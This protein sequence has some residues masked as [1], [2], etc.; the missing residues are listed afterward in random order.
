MPGVV[1]CHVHMLLSHLD[2]W[3]LATAPISLRICEAVDNLA[4]TLDAG[5]TYA[6]DAG[7]ID[8]GVAQAVRTGLIRG[9]RL[10]VS[11][12][13]ICQTGGHADGWVLSGRDMPTILP[14]LPGM[15]VTVVDGP[16]D[17]RRA[18]R[19]LVRAGADVLK[20]ATSGGVLS[21]RDDPRRRHLADDELAMLRSE[22]AAAG[23]RIMAHAHAN[24]GVKAAVRGGAASVEHGVWLDDEAIQMMLDAGTWLVPTLAAPREVLRYDNGAGAMPPELIA[25]ARELVAAHSDSFA[26]ALD[27]GVKVAL[28]SDSG[29]IAHGDN[30]RELELMVEAGMSGADGWR[31]ATA[32]GAALLGV[33]DRFGALEV[34]KRAD[35]IGVQGD[36]FNVTALRERID[37]VVQDGAIVRARTDA[38]RAEQPAS[39]AAA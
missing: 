30:L 1:D 39:G 16:E 32:G 28:G 11:I 38:V 4:T 31:A 2:L 34:G 5:V 7:G 21:P 3:R 15:P 27:A 10:Q 9:P 29:V 19:S 18:V 12:G 13:L 24:E 8:A 26:R 23:L 36:P 37:L 20:I 33:E 14:P 35:L 17:V 25:Q 22:A 6:R